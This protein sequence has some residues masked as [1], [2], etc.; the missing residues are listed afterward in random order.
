MSPRPMHQEMPKRG[1]M[2]K[3]FPLLLKSL[4]GYLAYFYVGIVF[5]IAVVAM[6]VI[7]PQYLRDLTNQIVSHIFDPANI[8][9]RSILN[10]VIILVAIY[11]STG[12]ANYVAHYLFVT[13]VQK[14]CKRLRQDIAE[15][16]NRMPLRYFDSN[17]TGDTM[18]RVTN[19]VDSISNN[20]DGTVSMII[21]SIFMLVAS[22]VMMFVT[23]W[24]MAL[25]AVSTVPVMA[26][27]LFIN[28]RI[29]MPSFRAR[30][31]QVG[32]VNALVEEDFT[33]QNIIWL[34][35]AS[36]RQE[37]KFDEENLTLS[38]AMFKAF[39]LGGLM[40]PMM[41]FLSYLSN[42]AV[43]LSGTLFII[44]G[45]KFGVDS[46][47]IAAFLLYVRM[48]QQPFTQIGQALIS[49][50]SV[51]AAAGRVYEFLA[52]EEL[53]DESD[54][55]LRFRD[56]EKEKIRGEVVFDHVSFGYD[57]SRTIIHD[58]SAKIAPGMKVA[59]VGPTGAGKTT[60]VNLLMRFYEIKSGSIYL[61]G[62][63]M[64]TLRKE[65]IRE[66]F[67]MV[68]QDTWVYE[69][70]LR[71]NLVYNTENVTD[72]EIE[73]ALKDANLEHFAKTLPDGLN[74]VINENSDISSGQKQLI[75][76]ARAMIRKAPL[77]ILDEATSNVDTRTEEEIQEAMDRLTR[78]RTSFVIAHRLSTIRNADMILVM[79]QGNIVEQGSHDE[80]IK[81]EGFYASLY[82]SQFAFE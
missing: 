60:M 42:A 6:E 47:I 72:E 7:A 22:S 44:N 64:A 34:F 56:G 63:D 24:S 3:N 13:A 2:K 4:K 54:K 32:V 76:I 68:L 61:D 25:I 17:A 81:K 43:L 35:N 40:H 75:T 26:I 59:I 38:K 79:D 57:E 19:D 58:F 53:P 16:I 12:I 33:G 23:S 5:L 37:G 66:I 51:L 8:D 82:N 1:T 49:A 73:Q 21:S 11:G 36:D 70:T 48:F 27:I 71:E 30:Q 62:V 67:G 78:G 18:S 39:V 50:Q 9:L 10:L 77:L 46:G 55:P 14:Y 28:M 15:K 74:H 65:E 29:A 41:N 52:E 31:K 45:N 20:L 80:L 69:G